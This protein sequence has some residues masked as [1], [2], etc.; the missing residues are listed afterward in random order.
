MYKDT[1]SGAIIS[2]KELFLEYLLNRE[3]I[4]AESGAKTFVEWLG[5]CT[6]K[7]GFLMEV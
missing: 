3:E 5:N 7:N 4:E 6:S 2:R 1:E